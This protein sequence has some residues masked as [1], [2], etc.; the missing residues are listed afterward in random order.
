ML[1]FFLSISFSGMLLLYGLGVRLTVFSTKI[2]RIDLIVAQK[3]ILFNFSDIVVDNCAICR[4]HIMDL[5]K[6]Q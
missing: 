6:S 1:S 5:C 4:N 2:L 3:K